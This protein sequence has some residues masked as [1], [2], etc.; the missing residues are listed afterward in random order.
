MSSLL[1]VLFVLLVLLACGYGMAVIESFV[2]SAFHPI[3]SALLLPFLEGLTLLRQQN[4]KPA[5]ADSFL[6][7]SAP[8]LMV[9]VVALDYLVLPFGPG[10]IGFDP[11]IGL[12][13][14]LVLLSPFVV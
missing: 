2:V 11:A 8:F 6:F 1:S 12:F 7:R 13:Y 14:F 5:R 9:A 3:G 4:L 10:L